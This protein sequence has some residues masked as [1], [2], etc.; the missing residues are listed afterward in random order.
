MRALSTTSSSV[1]EIAQ[2]QT[3]GS[4][5]KA[6]LR[7]PGFLSIVLVLV[8]FSVFLPLGWHD[9]VNYDDPDYVT[10]NPHVQS[11]LKW[12]NVTWA[13]MTGH[14]SNWH[15]LTWLSHMLD[16]QLFG[17]H[18][19]AQHL[20]NAGFH[21]IN[22]VLLFLL[23]RNLTGALWRSALVAALFALHPLHVE[24]VA[25]ISERK[26]VLST[27]FFLLTVCAYSKY[28]GQR[29]SSVEGRGSRGGNTFHASR[30]YALTLLFFA[31]GLMSKPM[32]VTL[33]FVLLLLDYWPLNRLSRAIP[34]SAV[35]GAGP[36]ATAQKQ[37]QHR[38]LPTLLFLL[39]EKIP[40]FALSLLSSC[41][42]FLVQ[43]K[44]G[45]VSTGI[46]LGAR[47]ANAL[48]SYCRYVGKM[49][50]PENL[51]VLYP[52]PGHWPAWEV[53]VSGGL[54]LLI[55]LLVA[56]QG[57]KRPYLWVGWLWFFGTLVP[58]I[59]LVQVGVQSMADRYTYLP[60]IGLFIMLV[61]GC[62]D[63]VLARLRTDRSPKSVSEKSS[64]SPPLE[65]RRPFPQTP[66]TSGNWSLEI[67][68]SLELGAWGFAASL[69]L[70]CCT[71]LTLRQVQYWRNSE[72]LFA[73]AVQV[74]KN[75]YLAY[76]NLGFYQ[77]A[78]GKTAEAMENY[79]M[80]LKIN[81]RYEDALN[82]LGYAFAG[83]KKYAEAIPYYEAALRVRPNHVEVHNNL[84][85]ALSELGKIDEAISQYRFVLEQKPDHA[86]AHN[87]LGIALAMRGQI[88]EAVSH[89]HAAIRYKPNYS[90]AHSNLG[91]AM[92]AQHKFDDA[93]KE[94][95]ESLRLQPTD[96]QAHNN[97]GNVLSEQ[98]RLPEAIAHYEQ[99]LHLKA[100][101]PEAHFNLGIALARQGRRQ[102]A[103][104]HY[105][106]ALRLKPDYA[107][108]KRQLET[109]S[110]AEQK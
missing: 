19:G 21:L 28:V 103:A 17:Q 1:S 42:T 97:L 94:Y 62:G 76:N 14:A 57:R 9:F 65:E 23:L 81:P 33:P 102:E 99:A 13:F 64:P 70:F 89:F 6:K 25:W 107:E 84:G 26:D 67:P 27:L 4:F 11:G 98:G 63:L 56:F 15:P 35:K 29:V 10:A 87:N 52:H 22:T 16:C 36:A 100:D 32:L 54:L 83:Q 86:D 88:E 45:A 85:N 53:A 74:T 20:I 50:W 110:A 75:N 60:L 92:A 59:G 8:T 104:T 24:S 73:H 18:P 31:L 66:A 43:Q 41:I 80:A 46:S 61:W 109:I 38:I 68:W 72:T 47:I 71:L 37:T 3:P 93:I 90:S 2:A 82:N 106:E 79:R 5:W 91:N 34:N 30:Y 49:F 105:A 78:A 44:G 95:Q 69:L 40:F 96:A 55:F 51:S 101:N 39:L 48:I 12:G 58:V 108:A 7:C 77:S